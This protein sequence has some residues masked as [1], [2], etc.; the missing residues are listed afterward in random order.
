MANGQRYMHLELSKLVYPKILHNA[1]F[2]KYPSSHSD[3]REHALVSGAATVRLLRPTVGPYLRERKY[4]TESDCE[5]WTA[6]PSAF[7]PSL[8]TF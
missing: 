4:G 5:A 8:A 2:L 6:R 1:N 3:H 7:N